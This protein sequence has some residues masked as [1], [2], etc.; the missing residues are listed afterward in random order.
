MEST[1]I[2]PIGGTAV[3]TGFNTHPSFSKLV[4]EEINNLIDLR[5]KPALSKPSKMKSLSD[6]LSLS[7]II[8]AAAI[9]LH[10]ISQDIRLMYS[11]PNTGLEEIDITISLPGSSIMPG[12][13]NPITVEA[14]M[15]AV[16]QICGY[17]YAITMASTLGEFELNMGIPLIGYNLQR[18]VALL[19]EA[20]N[21]LS[22]IVLD[23][24]VVDKD[25]CRELASKS[26]SLITVLS[27]II[28]YDKAEEIANRILE[29]MSFEEALSIAGLDKKTISKLIKLNK[30]TKPGFPVLE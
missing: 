6:L 26:S 24:I 20:L 30:W 8:K 4:I 29:G 2:V 5:L 1:K 21:K 12:K 7:G 22:S 16:C 19:S 23:N 9:D 3:G 28:G 18:E 15:L 11:G 25:R 14:I 10:K 13:K 27:P 17:D